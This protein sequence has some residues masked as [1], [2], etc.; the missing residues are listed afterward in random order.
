MGT[1]GVL[2]PKSPSIARKSAHCGLSAARAVFWPNYAENRPKGL[3]SP[4]C[5]TSRRSL[6]RAR[7]RPLSTEVRLASSDPR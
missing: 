5:L 3:F 6:V 7:H 2:A 4:S 1:G